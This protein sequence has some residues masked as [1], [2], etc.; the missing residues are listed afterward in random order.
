MV[1]RTNLSHR[2]N[3][4]NLVEKQHTLTI[5]DLDELSGA[6]CCDTKK[7]Q[8]GSSGILKP[9]LRSVSLSTQ[10]TSAFAI[11]STHGLPTKELQASC[12]RHLFQIIVTRKVQ[13]TWQTLAVGHVNREPRTGMARNCKVCRAQKIMKHMGP[14][15]HGSLLDQYESQSAL[16]QESAGPL[17]NQRCEI[18][19]GRK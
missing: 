10:C 14:R 16:G 3:S 6:T 17:E 5:L 7:H 15:C 12:Q 2:R 8:L 13:G 18:E 11:L 4:R 19:E 9:L 1:G